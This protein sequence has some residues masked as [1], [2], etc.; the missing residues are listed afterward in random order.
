MASLLRV[1]ASSR[2]EGSYSRRLGDAFVQH[3]QA[4]HEQAHVRVRDLSLQA[5][6]H[7]QATTIAGM[8][9][10]QPSV[11]QQQALQLSDQ[12][13]TELTA[14]DTL[15]ITTPMYNFALPSAL[16]AWL[17]HCVR[18]GRTFAF[19]GQQF[20]G[21]LQGKQAHVMI[22]YGAAGYLAGE[23]FAA[24]NFVEPY[25]R[26]I[27]GFMGIQDVTVHS[28]QA[29]TVAPAQADAEVQRLVAGWS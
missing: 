5:I 20:A 15:L 25:L 2:V 8:F 13:I 16:K 29:T 7:I 9:S 27:L 10:P 6:P 22:A 18:I 14:A 11:E 19:D 21:L 26:F 17:D 23:D 12:L 28:V 24:A 4:Q 1:D 3:W